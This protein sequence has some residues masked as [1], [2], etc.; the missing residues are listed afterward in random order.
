MLEV[1]PAACEFCV[2]TVQLIIPIKSRIVEEQI[3]M[4]YKSGF[5]RILAE[6][7]KKYK[8]KGGLK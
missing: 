2:N 4:E 5:G 8:G 6:R 1:Y 3:E 7:N